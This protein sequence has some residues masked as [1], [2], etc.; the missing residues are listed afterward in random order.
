MKYI[1]Q[2]PA[3]SYLIQEWLLKRFDQKPY[4]MKLT[5]L[6]SKQKKEI[7][8][9]TQISN[10]RFTSPASIISMIIG[11]VLL[12]VLAN[13]GF[14]KTYISHFPGFEDYVRPDGRQLH[15]TWIMHFHG[16][17]MIG[18]L[19]MLLVQPILILKGKVKLHRSVG[20]LSYVLAPL[21]LVSM[22]LV[23][24]GSLDR[25]VAPEEQAAVVARRMALDAPLIIF[26]AILYILAIVYKHRTA[27]HS[28]F[29][30]STAFMLIGPPLSRL[31]RAYF[32]YDRGGSIDQ[33]RNIAVFIALAVTVGD[34]LRLK[35]ISPFA[36]VLVFVL[37]NKIIWY[38]RDTPFW[39]PIGG[40][41]GKLF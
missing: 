24:L 23:T 35:R 31:L 10:T 29:M 8:D 14:Y 9:V 33:S 21:V 39:Q 7:A 20:R 36:L 13:V 19:L 30:V 12:I 38:I 32:D 15:F 16:M 5:D 41:L 4:I 18:W 22:Y 1:M 40:A 26:F 37:L 28:R 11:I 3:I 34:S 17:M 6:F 27:L 2:N 25:V